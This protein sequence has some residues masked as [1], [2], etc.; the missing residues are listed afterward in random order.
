M[1]VV[2][3]LFVLAVPPVFSFLPPSACYGPSVHR[4]SWWRHGADRAKSSVL[5]IGEQ[6]QPDANDG[7]MEAE[8]VLVRGMRSSQIKKMLTDMAISTV[9]LF[10]VGALLLLLCW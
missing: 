4:R 8:M 6:Q 3:L 5:C 10:E 1:T 9:G 2:V 7:A